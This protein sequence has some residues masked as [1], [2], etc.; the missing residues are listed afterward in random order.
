M[1][2]GGKLATSWAEFERL[3]GVRDQVSRQAQ[4]GGRSLWWMIYPL[5]LL[6]CALMAVVSLVSWCLWRG[7]YSRWWYPDGSRQR[8]DKLSKPKIDVHDTLAAMQTIEDIARASQARV[9]WISG[10]LLGLERLGHPLPHDKDMDLGLHV[11]DPH[12]LDFIRALWTSSSI[13]SLKPQFIS[14][15]VRN[16]NP[17]LQGIPGGI[18]RYTAAVGFEADAGKPPVKLDVFLHFP[19]SGGVVHGTRN[20]L[21][22]NTLPGVVRKVYGEASFS[23]PQDVHRYLTE[24]YGNYQNEVREFENSIDCPNV[25]DVFSWK[26]WTYLQTRQRMMLRLGRITRARQINKRLKSTILKGL[27]PLAVRQ[28]RAQRGS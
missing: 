15:K 12:C 3:A 2:S 20:S 9:F 4:A 23:V 28:S 6:E 19:C 18:I 5:T 16:Q 1:Q 17:D 7:V 14:R 21:W 11:D 27:L 24:N 22:W 13:V 25:M 8:P 26:S 10:T